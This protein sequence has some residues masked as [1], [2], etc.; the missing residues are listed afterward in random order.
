MN[1]NLDL[2]EILR[3]CPKGTPFYSSV[4]GDVVFNDI[5]NNHPYPIRVIYTEDNGEKWYAGFTSDGRFNANIKNS[6]C[7][8]FPSKDCRDWSK[9]CLQHTK[10]QKGDHFLWCNE[11]GNTLLSVFDRYT[12]NG[13]GITKVVSYGDV[14]G[15]EINI[16]RETYVKKFDPKWLKPGDGVLVRDNSGE[17]W[18]YGIFSYFMVEEG[19]YNFVINGSNWK[20]CIPQ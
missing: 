19:N 4:A 2:V 8:I 13:Q 15:D 20:K 7:T 5:R 18:Y 12:E 11:V 9:F 10:F 3:D 1:E 14:Y 6:E 16:E 17:E